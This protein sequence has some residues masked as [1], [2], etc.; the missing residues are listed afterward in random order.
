MMLRYSLGLEAEAQ[1]I[2]AAVRRV[3]EQGVLTADLAPKGNSSV[4]TRAAGDAVIN[5]LN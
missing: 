1:A 2:E 5:A 3:I 4:G